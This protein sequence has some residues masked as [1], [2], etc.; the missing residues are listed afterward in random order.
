MNKI[1]IQHY[2]CPVGELLLGEFNDQL[3]L[4]DWR[5]RKMRSTIDRRLTM[6]LKAEYMESDSE[7]LQLTRQQLVEYFNGHRSTFDLPLLMAGSE[8]Q[9]QVWLALLNI[10]YGQT[11]SYLSLAQT[12]NNPLAV[13]AVASANGANAMSIFIPCHRV[14]GSNGQLVGYAGGISAKEKLL[15][16][17]NNLFSA[18]D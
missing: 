10:P 15:H 8:F 14:I 3:C 13:R 18:K 9:K 11:T 5:Y 4:C 1:R 2:H 17:E 12:I 16:L 6:Q 7:L